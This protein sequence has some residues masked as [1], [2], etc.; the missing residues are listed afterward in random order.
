M[1]RGA[2]GPE[3]DLTKIKVPVELFTGGRDVLSTPQDMDLVRKRLAEG[4]SLA[5]VHETDDFGHMDY[6][7]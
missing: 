4:G 2:D 5:G 3:Y 1:V 6:I 7:W